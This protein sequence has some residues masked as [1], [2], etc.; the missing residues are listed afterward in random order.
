MISTDSITLKTN[1]YIEPADY[2]VQPVDSVIHRHVVEHVLVDSSGVTFPVLIPHFETVSLA[3]LLGEEAVSI[4]TTPAPRHLKTETNNDAYFDFGYQSVLLLVFILYNIVLIRF[5]SVSRNLFKATLKNN[6]IDK[7]IT[8]KSINVQIFLGFTAI[9][10]TLSAIIVACDLPRILDMRIPDVF[11]IDGR[12][13]LPVMTVVALLALTIYKRLLCKIIGAFSSDRYFAEDL[14]M[15]RRVFNAIYSMVLTPLIFIGS[16]TTE[17]VSLVIYVIA[18]TYL[19]ISLLSYI[20]KMKKIFITKKV[21]TLQ[22]FL[23]LCTVE[24]LPLSFL[25]LLLLRGA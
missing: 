20:I 16:F 5:G 18:A 9:I 2:Q 15:M 17:R 10:G 8:E 1:T 19:V 12:I 23:Y 22:W 7:F 13:M 24:V 21:S 11:N 4:T 14:I 25:L 3:T 6:Y